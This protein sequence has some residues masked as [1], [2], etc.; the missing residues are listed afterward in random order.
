MWEP[1]KHLRIKLPTANVWW[2]LTYGKMES[3]LLWEVWI[4]L[5]GHGTVQRYVFMLYT[6]FVQTFG[7]GLSHRTWSHVLVA[8]H[9]EAHFVPG[10]WWTCLKYLGYDNFSKSLKLQNQ[11]LKLIVITFFKKRPSCDRVIKR[12]PGS[13][14]TLD[15]KNIHSQR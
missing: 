9:L 11:S 15:R 8:Q 7:N 13:Y 5:F 10:L 6:R 14:M 1:V 3:V 12:G 4:W 2:R